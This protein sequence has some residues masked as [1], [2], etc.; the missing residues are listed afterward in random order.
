[1]N[2]RTIPPTPLASLHLGSEVKASSEEKLD[3]VV[4]KTTSAALD[5][6]AGEGANFLRAVGEA[7]AEALEREREFLADCEA[8]VDA[9]LARWRE[10]AA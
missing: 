8:L 7:A 2:L 1:M 5:D 4:G 10:G 6:T 9:G 3:H